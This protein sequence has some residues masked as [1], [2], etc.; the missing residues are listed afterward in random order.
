M[1]FRR[2]GHSGTALPG[3]RGRR[4]DRKK[5]GQGNCQESCRDNCEEDGLY[6]PF[7]RIPLAVDLEVA[8]TFSRDSGHKRSK[9]GRFRAKEWNRLRGLSSQREP[10]MAEGNRQAL[11][12]WDLTPRPQRSPR[13]H[14]R[15]RRPPKQKARSLDRAFR[16]NPWDSFRLPH[17]PRLCRRRRHR[18]PPRR[19]QCQLRW[20]RP[21]RRGAGFWRAGFRFP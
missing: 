7:H 11:S 12:H 19:P 6:L 10:A 14:F 13:N 1:P 9:A 17:P 15:S 20:L 21:W 5:R 4:A 16:F 2:F 3:L 8:G 18:H